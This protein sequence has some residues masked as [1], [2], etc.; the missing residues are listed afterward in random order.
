MSALNFISLDSHEIL[1]HL[2]TLKVCSCKN[3]KW[4]NVSKNILDVNVEFLIN[5]LSTSWPSWTTWWNARA[6]L[7]RRFCEAA[8]WTSW[9]PR[10]R[11]VTV[12]SRSKVQTSSFLFDTKLTLYPTALMFIY[13][14]PSLSTVRVPVLQRLVEKLRDS[15]QTVSNLLDGVEAVLRNLA[16]MVSVLSESSHQLISF[17]NCRK[18]LQRFTSWKLCTLLSETFANIK[19]CPTEKW[20]ECVVAWS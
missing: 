18:S 3:D 6:I 2:I 17:W 14:L 12:A 5:V 4:N 1:D 7:L 19:T 11:T 15:Q 16:A 8:S 13:R 10:W 9:L 20:K